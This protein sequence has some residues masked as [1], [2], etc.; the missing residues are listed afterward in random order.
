MAEPHLTLHN[1]QNIPPA[2]AAK[3]ITYLGTE[4]LPWRGLD[5]NN[6][7]EEFH[8]TLIRTKRL[9][10]KPAQKITLISTYNVPHFLHILSVII[11]TIS[12]LKRLDRELRTVIND[13]LHLPQ[14]TA[15]GLLY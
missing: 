4:I 7:E 12:M 13:I 15:N 5:N 1:G 6:T 2:H 9:A 10:L 14:S 8:T 3:R 11:P